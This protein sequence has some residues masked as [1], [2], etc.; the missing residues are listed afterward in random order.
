MTNLANTL[1]DQLSELLEIFYQFKLL[2][3][4]EMKVLIYQG[5][6]TSVDN[7]KSLSIGDG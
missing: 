3:G 4:S 1:E 7:A 5:N 2:R 6:E